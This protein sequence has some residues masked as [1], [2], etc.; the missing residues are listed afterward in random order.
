M[1]MTNDDFAEA[2]SPYHNYLHNLA[3]RRTNYNV[4]AAKDLVQDTLLKAF[5]FWDKFQQG[6]NLKGWLGTILIRQSINDFHQ[7][8]NFEAI[9]YTEYVTTHDHL[10]DSAI[11]N[12]MV[13]LLDEGFSDEVFSA[14]ELLPEC[15]KSAVLL[16]DV[17]GY[18]GSEIAKELNIPEGTV[19]SRVSRGR[20]SL[21]L[22]LQSIDF[23]T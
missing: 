19:K 2:I 18:S 4:E 12:S 3:L 11:D 5:K 23:N 10:P 1:K 14:L 20:N 6:T 15:Y 22:F 16:S 21:R 9:D 13:N 7:R 8:K 17:E